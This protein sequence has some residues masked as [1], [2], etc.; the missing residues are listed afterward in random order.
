MPEGRQH[1]SIRETRTQVL[2]DALLLHPPSEDH[3]PAI[4]S[5]NPNIWEEPHHVIN[6]GP[7]LGARPSMT[8]RPAELEHATAMAFHAAGWSLQRINEE[9]RI[10]LKRRDP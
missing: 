6:I 9:F 2:Q 7:L 4:L 3:N 8:A 1:R 5:I 10:D